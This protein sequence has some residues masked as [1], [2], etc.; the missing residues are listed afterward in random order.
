[1]ASPHLLRPTKATLNCFI[2]Q[3][4]VWRCKKWL[5]LSME[6][7]LARS[8]E[9]VDQYPFVVIKTLKLELAGKSDVSG[10]TTP[11]NELMPR[12]MRK[13]TY[14]DD[15]L[16]HVA[17]NIILAGRD[18]S[19]VALSWFFW[20]VSANPTPPSSARPYHP[21]RLHAPWLRLVQLVAARARVLV[22]MAHVSRSRS[23]TR[24]VGVGGVEEA[25]AA[26]VWSPSLV[27]AAKA[28]S[29]VFDEMHKPI[30]SFT[31]QSLG[32]HLETTKI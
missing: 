16:Q 32:D 5:G 22:A 1:M 28:H 31:P 21:S 6:S 20:L 13:G 29:K 11:H 9:H 27:F 18:T 19:S 12:F 15:S 17:L 3:E 24:H 4:C 7:T 25:T 10:A 14:S 26:M 30:V 2:F 23:F 8:V